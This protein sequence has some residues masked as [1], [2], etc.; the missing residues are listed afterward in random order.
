V[1]DGP[2]LARV[3]IVETPRKQSGTK[4]S[5]MSFQIGNDE[6]RKRKADRGGRPTRQEVARRKALKKAEALKI[7]EWANMRASITIAEIL[8]IGHCPLCNRK[9]S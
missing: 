5:N 8:G 7:P 2:E 4:I 1:E 9:S 6:W 3:R